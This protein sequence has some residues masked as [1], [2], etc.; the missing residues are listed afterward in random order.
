MHQ[1]KNRSKSKNYKLESPKIYHRLRVVTIVITLLFMSSAVVQAMPQADPKPPKD[2]TTY[3]LSIPFVFGGGTPFTQT[4]SVEDED[5]SVAAGGGLSFGTG[6]FYALPNNL[7]F[8]GTFHYQ[9]SEIKRGNDSGSISFKRLVLTPEMK[10][11][12]KLKSNSFVNIG[13]GYGFYLNGEL[14]IKDAGESKISGQAN[15]KDENGLHVLTEYEEKF[16]EGSLSIGMKYYNVK[17]SMKTGDFNLNNLFGNGLDLY[18]TYS[19]KL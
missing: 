15:Y 2:S 14:N 17:Y 1:S 18:V 6:L 13:G 3:G 11:P 9:A 16:S 7:K 8:G 4:R 10:I 19:L 12:I 5:L